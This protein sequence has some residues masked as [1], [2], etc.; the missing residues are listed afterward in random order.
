MFEWWALDHNMIIHL[1]ADQVLRL[2][3]YQDIVNLS[4]DCLHQDDLLPSMLLPHFPALKLLLVTMEIP[5]LSV[6][7]LSKKYS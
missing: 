3:C 1:S 6:W 5:N 2:Y 4:P 7:S